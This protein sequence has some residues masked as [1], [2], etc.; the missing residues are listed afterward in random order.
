M[1]SVTVVVI[2][3]HP[4]FRQGIVSLLEQKDG[5]EIV[6]QAGTGKMAV[7]AVKSHCPDLVIL[8]LGLPDISGIEV[9]RQIR[10]CSPKSRI[11][12]LTVSEDEE[13][14]LAAMRS[15]AQGYLL[16]DLQPAHFFDHLKMA[17][18]GER[19]ISQRMA[20]KLIA[21]VAGTATEPTSLTAREQEVLGYVTL[22]ATNRE[23][24]DGLFISENT[25]KTHV[26]NILEKLGLRNRVEAARYGLQ[27]GYG[28]ESE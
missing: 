17:F 8:D 6:G 14:L 1:Q 22:G 11:L 19:P 28:L 2:D 16:K 25:V 23:I 24:A 7:E 18:S 13:D 5:F 15:G 21:G 3:D 27:Q 4:L 12:I 10:E 20:S 9:T 26:S